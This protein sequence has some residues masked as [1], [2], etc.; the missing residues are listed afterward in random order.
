MISA[1]R[2]R[3]RRCA[4]VGSPIEHSLSPVLHHAAYAALRLKDWSYDRFELTE[5]ELPGFV[6]G[7]DGSWRGLSVTMPLKAAALELGEVD[8][9][10]AL[11]GAANTVIFDDD[12]TRVYN[13]DVGGL[14]SAVRGGGARRVDQVTILG[15]GATA[16]ASLVSAGRLGARHVV[17]VARSL[18]KAARL[19]EL[20]DALGVEL[21]VAGW[22]T[23]LPA[24][25]LLIST[26]VAGAADHRA[27]EIAASAAVVFDA[28]YDPWPTPLAQAAQA[29]GRT[30]LSGL[31]LLVGQAVLQVEL[32]TGLQVSPELLM[33]AGRTALSRSGQA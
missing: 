29:A 13:T 31:D 18:E 24:A 17:V 33:S 7:L 16:R 23:A 4:V 26:V 1:G 14:M 19:A 22:R 20:A 27:E 5:Q 10:A 8:E 30:V 3:G 25:D 11:V 28:I 9:L 15:A 2:P 6:A 12:Q 21:D 32:M